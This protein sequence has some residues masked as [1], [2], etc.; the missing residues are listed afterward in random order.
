MSS[1]SWTI[2]LIVISAL[3]A[4]AAGGN[5]GTDAPDVPALLKA[6]AVLG[7]LVMMAACA[8]LWWRHRAPLIV[9][10]VLTGLTLAIPT[11]AL[12]ALVALAALTFARKGWVRW[13][14]IAAV[15]IST[16]VA[17]CWDLSGPDSN[18]AIM[19]G[20]SHVGTPARLALYWVVPLLAAVSVAP[21]AAFGIGRRMLLER[22]GARHETAAAHETV[23]V[24]QRE[25]DQQKERQEIARELHDTLA[26]DLSQV[27]LHAGALELMVDGANEHA[28][29]AARV[30]RE[31]TQRSMDDLRQMVRSLRDSEPAIGKSSGLAE[32]S[33]LIDTAIEDGM[34]VRA[35]VMVNDA[36][37][38]SPRVAHAAFRAVQEAI[39]NA[40]RHAPGAALSVQV[41]GTPE[42]GLTVHT[43]N[44]LSDVAPSSRGGR[45]GLQGMRERVELV[46]GTFEA[47]ETADG[48]FGIKVWMPWDGIRPDSS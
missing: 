37:T 18:I 26:A 30:V 31:S 25:V 7:T 20:P 33:D 48:A 43:S 21:F 16:C 29:A 10:S 13:C 4:I 5:V 28:A 27:A 44:P 17:F 38:C 47:G 11:S 3:L 22:D 15:F 34:D 19:F 41:R 42:T 24:L 1:R 36:A 14:F 45:H 32:V 39:S 23:S 46:G 6:Y 2:T 35:R 9:A 40:R 8:L 12:P